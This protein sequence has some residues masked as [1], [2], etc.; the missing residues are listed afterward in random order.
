M[1]R[2]QSAIA[3]IGLRKWYGDHLVLDGVDLD[4]AE[5]AH[6]APRRP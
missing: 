1:T 3:A 5:G 2:P 4:V 6:G